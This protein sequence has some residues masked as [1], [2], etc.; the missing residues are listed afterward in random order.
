MLAVRK[1]YKVGFKHVAKKYFILEYL[2]RER[3][4]EISTKTNQL[5]KE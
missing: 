2:E 5:L 3:D 1:Y 4:E